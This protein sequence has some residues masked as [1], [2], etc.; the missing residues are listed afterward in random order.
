MDKKEEVKKSIQ[1]LSLEEIVTMREE[2]VT[3][4]NNY[5]EKNEELFSKPYSD[6]GYMVIPVKLFTKMS[7]HI[8]ESSMQFNYLL[9]A[10]E[11]FM[12]KLRR[13]V[14]VADIN[15]QAVKKEYLKQLV[16]SITVGD[17]KEKKPKK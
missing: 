12:T 11:E 16:S 7:N 14:V 15:S 9:G 17:L 3:D 13:A 5:I 10:V 4:V 6:E 2:I 1:D 8:S